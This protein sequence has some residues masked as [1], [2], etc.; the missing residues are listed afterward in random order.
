[1]LRQEPFLTC[2]SFSACNELQC[3]PKVLE[4]LS[5]FALFCDF[6]L[7]P[8]NNVLLC[9]DK[10][11]ITERF[12]TLMGS[13]NNNLANQHC[14]VGEGVLKLFADRNVDY[15]EMAFSVPRTFSRH[16]TMKRHQNKAG[17]SCLK[18]NLHIIGNF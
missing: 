9:H 17:S 13:C 11:G 18:I 14:F 15:Q 1:M 12:T 10:T 16:Y 5:N 3:L 2:T 4:H 6:P 7:P 8:Q